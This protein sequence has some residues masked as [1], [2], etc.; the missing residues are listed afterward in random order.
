MG[1]RGEGRIRLDDRTEQEVI[2]TNRAIADA[3]QAM[4]RG[5]LG[6]LQGFQDGSSGITEAAHL[7]R[8]GMEASRR[9]GRGGG[10]PT[11]MA[12]AYAVL[13]QAGFAAVMTVLA[14][15]VSAVLTYGSGDAD[16]NG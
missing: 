15:A 14:E 7:L 1:A 8:A 3:E 13:D 12:D 11:T 9:D 16:P 2:F 6:V 5:I 4:G 10:K